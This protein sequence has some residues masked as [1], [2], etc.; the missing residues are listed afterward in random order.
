MA[1]KAWLAWSSG[2]DSAWA[3]QVVRQQSD[4]E[5]VGLLTTLTE[6]YQR[7]SMHAVRAELVH[8]QAEAVGLPLYP[9]YIPTPCSD[10]AYETAMLAVMQQALAQGVRRIVFG[11]LFLEEVRAYREQQ[12]KKIGICPSFPLW[13][14]NTAKLSQ[15]M[16]AQGLRAYITCL[17][18]KKV[19]SSLAGRVYD[20][21][22]LKSLP[23]TVDPCGENG[24]FHTFVYAGPMF[25]HALAVEISES[26]AR[27]GFV[28]TDV[29]RAATF[30]DLKGN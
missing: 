7:V 15:A 1:P 26:V 8:A 25:K 10:K 17:D 14:Q 4:L 13:K 3:L 16:L 29:R 30:S 21:H 22:F 23:V 11:D 27:D 2:K 6:K 28:F 19:P 9:V 24:E 20:E 12:L 5:I 18:P